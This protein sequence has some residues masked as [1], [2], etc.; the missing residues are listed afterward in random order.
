MQEW[1]QMPYIQRE[2][3]LLRKMHDN[4]YEIWDNDKNEALDDVEKLLKAFPEY[5]N[6]VITEQQIMP[7]LRFR[8]E[9]QDYRDRVT[10]LDTRRK[11]CHDAAIDSLNILNRLCQAHDLPKFADVDTKNRYAVADFVGNYTGEL[12]NM[13]IGNTFDQVTYQQQRPYDTKVVRSRIDELNAKFGDI[14]PGGDSDGP[15]YPS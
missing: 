9:G 1:R 3:A 4:D 5:S 13:G 15:T 14:I 7:T 6:A 12:Y 8:L 2:E 11:Q 10:E